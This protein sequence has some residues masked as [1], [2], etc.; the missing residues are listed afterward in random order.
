MVEL[1]TV[2]VSVKVVAV[3][4]HTESAKKPAVGTSYTSKAIEKESTQPFWVV[5]VNVGEY[6]PYVAYV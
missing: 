4:K 6:V 2:E 1:A 3:P 5:M